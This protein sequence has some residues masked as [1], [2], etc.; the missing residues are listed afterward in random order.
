MP[1]LK[2]SDNAIKILEKRY[3]KKNNGGKVIEKPEDLFKRVA[4][5]ISLADAKYLLKEE[6]E[7]L[8][9]NQ[10]YF[11][12]VKTK[13]FQ[14]LLRKNKK[15]KKK[16]EKTQK[17]FYNLMTSLDFLP[18]SPTLFNANRDLQQLA[19]CF[20]LP[21]EDD[22][23]SIFKSLHY[24]AKISKSGSGTGFD[25][26][27]LRPKNDVISSVTGF[28]SG[29]L[30]FMKIFDAVTEQ[31]KLGGLR[32]GAHMGILRV[33]HPDIEEFVTI[34]AREKV[35]ENFNI[36][37]AITNKFMEALQKNK[38]Y[39]L[40]NPRTQ[41]EV[42]QESAEKIFE[43]ICETAYKTGDPGLIFLDKINKDNPTPEL[44]ILESTDSC[45]EQPL[46]PYESANLGSINLSNMVMNGNINFN[47]LKITVH[48]AVHFLDNVIDMCNYPNKETKEIVYSNRKIGLGVMGFADILIKLKI[49][50][51]SERAV[52]TAEKIIGFIRKEADTKSVE[53][54]KQRLT[55][56]NWDGSSYNRK[57]KNF[58]GKHMP[59]RNATRLTL[60]P[61]GSISIIANTSFGI[62]PLFALSFVRTLDDGTELINVDKNFK[63]ALE[64][65][66]IYNNEFMKYIAKKGSIQQMHSI[67]KDIRGVFVVSYDISPEYHVKIQAAFQK[68]VD[69]AVSKTVTLPEIAT[70]EDVKNTY[71]LA[72]KLGCKGISIYRFGSREDQVMFLRAFK[73]EQVN[74]TN[75]LRHLR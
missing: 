16:L 35:L 13:Q 52:K 1:K 65:K 74:L 50:Y 34:K 9:D 58:R 42:K 10:E 46:L 49:P 8:D 38:S 29:P 69:N 48:K 27:R 63:E 15:V 41:K 25:F 17:E 53:L 54:A 75:W 33:D 73:E 56:P 60:A 36:S 62:E 20:V 26:S 40:I 66:K 12:L 70:V 71:L 4:N 39:S 61:T 47:K 44:G 2:L 11:E 31:I 5:N 68:H 45:G 55:F 59:I 28:S 21:V 67:P 22:L 14:S 72:Y 19:A 7:G 23:D 3:L 18:N 6:I 64:K 37:V 43:L 51:N 24:A 57:S 30:S 32:R